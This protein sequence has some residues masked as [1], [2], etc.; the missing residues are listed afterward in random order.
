[1]WKRHI[2]RRL[3]RPRWETNKNKISKKVQFNCFNVFFHVHLLPVP[4]I[5]RS[6]RRFVWKA[7]TATGTQTWTLAQNQPEEPT[8]T[9]RETSDTGKCWKTGHKQRI[10]KKQTKVN[11]YTSFFFSYF[12]H[13][14]HPIVRNNFKLIDIRYVA[15]H[16]IYLEF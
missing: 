7:K 14:I 1:M 15:R 9:Q 13:N 11:F 4:D 2:R 8:P 10:E 3:R 12:T 5:W 6:R 16:K